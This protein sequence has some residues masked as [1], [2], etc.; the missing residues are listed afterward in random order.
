M[1]RLTNAII[2]AMKNNAVDKAGVTASLRALAVRNEALTEALRIESLGGAENYARLMKLETEFAEWRKKAGD[3]LETAGR[4]NLINREMRVRINLAG[5]SVDRVFRN[6]E[7]AQE[8]RH[9]ANGR[10]VI[11]EG[12]PLVAE[13]YALEAESKELDDRADTI[14][15]SVGA[16]CSKVTTVK[17]LLELWPEAVE[18]LPAPEQKAANLPALPAADLNALIGLPS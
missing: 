16:A 3:Y 7:G 15:R 4:G 2:S 13:F 5:I 12:H 11:P 10:H 1:S 8:Y 9:A 6:S 14:K 17:K 18:L